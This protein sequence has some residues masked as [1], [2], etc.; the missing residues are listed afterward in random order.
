MLLAP[1]TT[2]ITLKFQNRKAYILVCT[3]FEPKWLLK[4]HAFP[5]VIFVGLQP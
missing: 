5:L 2:W 4:F 1:K 3:V